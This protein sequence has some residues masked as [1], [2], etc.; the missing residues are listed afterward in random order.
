M[1][2]AS[3]KILLAYLLGALTVVAGYRWLHMEY[4]LWRHEIHISA[5]EG[6]L[7]EETR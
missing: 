1:S 5:I 3:K 7:T 6:F 2:D 4:T